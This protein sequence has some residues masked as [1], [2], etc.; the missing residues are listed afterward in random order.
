M[1]DFKNIFGE[2]PKTVGSWVID[3]V[4]LRYFKEK[5]NV[6]ACVICRDQI[7]T[8]GFTLN[9]GYYNQGYYPS[10]YN[11][12]IPAQTVANMLDMPIFRMLG[13]DPIYA[14]EDGIRKSVIGVYTLEPAATIAQDSKWVRWIFERLTEEKDIGFS[15]A[16]VGQENTFLWNT[17]C[18]GFDAQMPVIEELKQS[19]KIKVMNIV[20]LSEWF[21][22]RY[23]LT[24]VTSYSATQDWCEEDLK[25]F[26]Y[27]SR[28]YRVSFL[29]D[30]NELFIRDLN[31]FNE[32]YESRYYDKTLKEA[33]SVF[34][35]LPLVKPHEWSTEHKR[36]KIE[37]LN[38]K[39]GQVLKWNMVKF[40]CDE[41]SRYRVDVLNDDGKIK[42][43]C[44]ENKIELCGDFNF[45]ININTLPVFKCFEKDKIKC[46]HNGFE[47][48]A[49]I[50]SGE[51][52]KFENGY[53]IMS[54]NFKIE[55]DFSMDKFEKEEE[56]FTEEY[57][58]NK[59]DLYDYKSLENTKS[60][61][62]K[63]AYK[64]VIK[65]QS[66]VIDIGEKVSFKIENLNNEGNIYYTLDGSEPNELFKVYNGEFEIVGECIVKAICI[67]D[68]FKNSEVC[69]SQIYESIKID[70]IKGS[71]KPVDRVLYN[72][73]GLDGFIDRE[74]G[75]I[76]YNDGN[77]IGY[78]DDID[79]TVKLEKKTLIKKIGL[80]F[81]QDTR[82]WIYYPKNIKF[83]VSDD[84]L[85]F[86]A[87]KTYNLDNILEWSEIGIENVFAEFNEECK[88]IR[89]V[90][91]NKK[92]GP[93]DSIMP[94][95]GPIY[96]FVDQVIIN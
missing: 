62:L 71:T 26:W 18:K 58:E 37:F 9:G 56:F 15:F 12:F 32:L 16:Q 75:S 49:K 35:A 59:D 77:W 76:H 87:I 64:P 44:S 8:D 90:C 69:E 82:A 28:F 94:N 29:F 25:T 48:Y 10:I 74:L 63:R 54:Q 70:S 42:I 66:S 89:V 51:F 6:R 34:D 7:G 61:I 91:E 3:I 79:I 30:N 11:E 46:E 60:K 14:F 5:Y 17:M 1:E 92:V 73:R 55:I 31:L 23:R 65:P 19:G 20:E 22:Y 40:D 21:R 80:R 38:S 52:V 86:K 47:Y 45:E 43:V 27:N 72:K 67:A 2:Y 78:H 41:K 83:E 36:N 24:P 88:Y 95:E 93:Q 33:E 57:L 4:S 68:R 13:P 84:G 85:I 53:K 81:L 96:I 50:I 39:T